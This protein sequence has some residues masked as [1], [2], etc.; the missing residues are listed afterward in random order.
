MKKIFT[1]ITVALMA[2][3]A[4]A[5]EIAL[6]ENGG[7][8][9]N[10]AELSTANAKVVLGNDRTSKP[11]D[12]KLSGCKAY[13]SQ[14]FGQTVQVQNEDTGEMEDK[15]RVVYVVGNQ[16]PKDKELEG[17]KSAGSGYKPE[18]GNLPQSGTYYMFTP[19]KNGHVCAF[20]ILNYD[21]SFYVVKGSDG[22]A[23][24]ASEMVLKA[25]GDEPTVVELDADNKVTEKLTG[26]VEFDVVANETYYIFC[27][28][29]KLSFGGYVFAAEGGEA[30][31]LNE[32]TLW[33]GTATVVGWANQ[34]T[35]LTDGGAELKAVGATAGDIIRFYMTA[36]DNNWEVELMDGHWQGMYVRW[37]EYDH[38]GTESDGVTPR[39]Y[40]IIDLTNQGYAD[41]VLTE[42]DITKAT[43]AGGW[44]N[45]FLLNGDGNLT[46]T[47]LS[48]LTERDIQV[49][50][51]EED[52]EHVSIIDKFTGNW[53]GEETNTH[54]ADGTVTY[55]GKQWGGLSAWLCDEA[56][57]P[58]DWSAYT[59]LVFEFAE[60]T[61]AACQ[62]FIQTANEDIK[63][64]G[65][66]GITKLECPFD[67]KDMSQVKQAA[68]QAAEDATYQISAI[69]LVKNAN[70]IE[71]TVALTRNANAPLYNLAGVRVSKDYKGIVIQNG[72]KFIQK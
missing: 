24:A 3:S 49:G 13:T 29:S 4:S 25:D 45:V 14:Y 9:N 2:M 61:P 42:A 51:G 7:T 23:L 5:Q 66:A 46:V 63:T 55:N 65:N 34:P 15:T 54:N 53:N 20:I 6:F 11:Y 37:A 1:L 47:R 22:Q 67:D 64:W 36:P 27:T 21:K 31:A 62:G 58:S 72:R 43:T 69:Y 57:N 16:N 71:E 38:G 18:S 60:A 28:G 32:V 52:G 10:G 12:V 68:L 48:L 26:T 44:G 17:D 59:K 40:T 30:P 19:T 8:Y 41:Y 56:E 50:P 33:E 35:F 39:A 70:G